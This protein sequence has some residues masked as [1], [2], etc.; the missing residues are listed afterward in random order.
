ML[1]SGLARVNEESL[2]MKSHIKSLLKRIPLVRTYAPPIRSML[3]NSS[4]RLG[5]MPAK[6][7]LD[8]A[9][10]SD[11]IQE[12]ISRP[13]GEGELYKAMRE[14]GIFVLPDHY[15][16]PFLDPQKLPADF[17]TSR[18]S[19]V[20]LTLN[21]D[22][23]LSW[24]ETKLV[25]YFQE[26]RSFLPINKED[27][28]DSR[29]YLVNGTYMAVDA[30][31]YYALIRH[32]RP[33][34]I[35]EVGAGFSTLFAYEALK[36]G[37][38]FDHTQLHVVEPYPEAIIKEGLESI[39]KVRR[40]FV[41]DVQPAFFDQLEAGDILFIDSTHVVKEGNDVL[42]LYL[43][44]LPRLKPGVYVHVHDINL[45]EP[46]PSCY[47]DYG[48]FWNEQYLLQAYLINN[49]RVKILWPGNYLMCVEPKR[50]L[51]LFPDIKDMR[52]VYPLSG[53]SAFWF[54]TI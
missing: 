21:T 35:I 18:S 31:M 14:R 37:N 16:R 4:V 40:E 7:S 6:T 46:Y 50:M 3:A 20:G 8:V 10:V 43:E 23:A 5:V 25:E 32:L 17:W 38:S 53:P 51:K 44:V 11:I 54:Q 2:G 22:E 36:R 12:F 41:Q 42:Y 28:P 52:A 15:Y 19:L 27:N 48:W 45:P 9:Q 34:R 1:L 26:L 49:S 30:H 24:A 13:G 39:A 33:K 47:L 29:L